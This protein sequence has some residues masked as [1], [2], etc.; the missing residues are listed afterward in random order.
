MT[1]MGGGGFEGIEGQVSI[2][3]TRESQGLASV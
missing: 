1:S 3:D 2:R